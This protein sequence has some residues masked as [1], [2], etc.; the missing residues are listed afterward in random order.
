MFEHLSQI[1]KG[2]Y[3]TV[4]DAEGHAL[5]YKVAEVK[6]YDTSASTEGIFSKTGPSQIILITCDGEWV[7]DEHQFNKRLVVVARP[8]Q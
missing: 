7:Q 2:D 1:R 5:V 6:L 4:A 8:A 3:I